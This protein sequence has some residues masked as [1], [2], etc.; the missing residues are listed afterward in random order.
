MA[1]YSLGDATVCC[2]VGTHGAQ[3]DSSGTSAQAFVIGSYFDQ[4]VMPRYTDIQGISQQVAEWMNDPL[5]GYRTNEV[6]GW[7][8]PPSNVGCGGRG[9]SS[10]YLMEQPTDYLPGANSTR[11]TARGKMYHLENM[12]L[13]PWFAQSAATETF[14]GSV[15]LPGYE[16]VLP[17]AQPCSGSRNRECPAVGVSPGTDRG[18]QW[19]RVDRLLGRL[20]FGQG[21]PPTEEMCLRNG[22]SS[23]QRLL[24]R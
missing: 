4:G 15:Q 22:T 6:P 21:H 24:R 20:C 14:N 10:S 9:E 11:V 13:L 17:H 23:S 3:P 5:H 2:S 7:L 12:A 18:A 8:K 19:T 1:F 16:G